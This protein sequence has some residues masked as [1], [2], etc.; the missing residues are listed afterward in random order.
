MVEREHRCDV[1]QAIM[2]PLGHPFIRGLV[3]TVQQLFQH[4]KEE[5]DGSVG[6]RQ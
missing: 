6:F 4:P 1:Y 5:Q 2:V 3:E